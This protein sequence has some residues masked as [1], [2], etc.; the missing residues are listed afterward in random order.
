[1]LKNHKGTQQ[2][3]DSL[4]VFATKIWDGLYVFDLICLTILMFL[5]FYCMEVIIWGQAQESTNKYH[6]SFLLCSAILYWPTL[7]IISL[8]KCLRFVLD[9]IHRIEKKK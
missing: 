3:K 7:M 9:E 8:F 6:Q 4:I 5:F 1:M 2:L